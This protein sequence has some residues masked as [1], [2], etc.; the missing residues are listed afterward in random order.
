MHSDVIRDPPGEPADLT[1]AEAGLSVLAEVWQRAVEQLG[2]VAPPAQL[3]ALLIVDGAGTMNLTR[4]ARMLGASTSATSK[5]CDRLVA[6]GLLAR[7]PAAASRREITLGSTESGHR[8]AQWVQDQRRAALDQTLASLSPEGRRD[9][10]R[11][12][13]ELA[14]L[15]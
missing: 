6:A 13:A 9:L 2:S 3:R 8:V 4:L 14:R 15:V 10:A 1:R 12:L 7:G 5:L 11:G